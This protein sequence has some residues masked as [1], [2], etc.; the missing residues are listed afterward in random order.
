MV[1]ICFSLHFI[2]DFIPWIPIRSDLDRDPHH[3]TFLLLLRSNIFRL[4]KMKK[5][6]VGW[7]NGTFL[8]YLLFQENKVQ[9]TI[10]VFIQ[11][12]SN[13][14]FPFRIF[15]KKDYE[16]LFW[17]IYK[18][19]QFM[20]ENFSVSVMT[21]NNNHLKYLSRNQMDSESIIKNTVYQGQKDKKVSVLLS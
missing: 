14:Q 3:W 18:I 12:N 1:K 21:F 13:L 20:L 6:L 9:F 7:L 5:L 10:N 19:S 16:T 2:S 15:L 4:K 17:Y 8:Y 11:Q